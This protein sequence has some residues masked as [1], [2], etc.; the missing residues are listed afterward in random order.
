[1]PDGKFIPLFP[2]EAL[3]L[4]RLRPGDA[5]IRWLAGTVPMPLVVTALKGDLIAC[6]LWT[7]DRATGAEIDP[8]LGWSPTF[9]GSYLRPPTQA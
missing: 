8:E 7:F 1:M 3:W 9:T 5:V 4:S 6:G 2:E